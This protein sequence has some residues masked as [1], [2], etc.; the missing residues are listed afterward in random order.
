MKIERH[1]TVHDKTLCLDK[2]ESIDLIID[3]RVGYCDLSIRYVNGETELICGV[4][5]KTIEAIAAWIG[6]GREG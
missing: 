4:S 2:I 3:D 6:V 5:V 1:L